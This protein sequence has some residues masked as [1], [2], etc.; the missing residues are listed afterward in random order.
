MVEKVSG[1]S[2]RQF[3]KDRIFDPL[4]MRDTTII[5][6]YPTTI[7][8]TNGYSKNEQGTYKICESPWEHTGMGQFM[9]QL[10]TW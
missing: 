9:Q 7:P 3:T 8:I 6:Y 1:K 5:D 4:N 2:L 10:K